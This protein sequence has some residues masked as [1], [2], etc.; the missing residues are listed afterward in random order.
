MSALTSITRRHTS[1]HS[2]A[3]ARLER[4]VRRWARRERWVRSVSWG[5]RA[6]WLSTGAGCTLAAI[7]RLRPWLL[8]ER[9][10][11][12]TAALTLGL[13]LSALVTA[14]GWPPR[15]TL[16]RARRFDRLFGLSER[17][18][19]AL[20]LLQS[21][22]LPPLLG[23]RQLEDAQRAAERVDV[24]ARLPLRV[25]KA[26]LAALLGLGALLAA[27]LLLP[28]PQADALRARQAWEQTLSAQVAA[29]EAQIE[30]IEAAEALDQAAQQA[31]T[32]P[33]QQAADTLTQEGITPQEAVAALTEAQQAL[34]ALSDGMPPSAQQAYQEAAQALAGTEAGLPLAQALQQADLGATAD[35]LDT[36]ATEAGEG[37]LSEAERQQL[38]DGLETAA[39]ALEA[40]NPAL[41]QQFRQAAQALREGDPNAA[42]QALHEAATLAAQ[43]DAALQQSELAQQAQ[44]AA[45]TL[46]AS[47]QALT[48][49][50]QSSASAQQAANAQP[51]AA[52]SGAQ[53]GEASA[54][55]S[56][57]ASSGAGGEQPSSAA[58]AESGGAGEN[59]AGGAPQAG[60][61]AGGDGQEG[62][63]LSEVSAGEG[64]NA[65]SAAEG[66][67]QSYTS[68]NPST[69]L[70][71]ESN[72]TMTLDVESESSPDNADQTVI[73]AP[74]AE[75][76]EA[77]LGYGEVLRRY[78]E[79][80][81][82]ALENGRIPLDQRDVIHDYFTSLNQQ[83]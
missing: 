29:L 21:G 41:A 50:E 62:T 68:Q 60:T 77:A 74:S 69:A 76:A 63:T 53:A 57:G 56:Q 32:E 36:L 75:G 30:A 45:Q 27:L 33:L 81:N 70:G 4:D 7:G 72:Q 5:V 73:V 19:T 39:D 66:D 2:D 80:V 25:H 79:A 34:Q 23:A 58:Q 83:P 37:A 31:L 52:T 3:Y 26:E 44:A 51:Q 43:Q 35:A 40:D 64:V 22:A 13:L 16:S 9:I 38:A 55:G 8:P 11:E 78:R 67:I 15:D 6:L 28:N 1:P 20:E 54:G 65:P 10:A 49:A 18:S 61:G 42:Q 47:T 14:W 24:R 48:Q 12:A 17:V 71:G 59:A 46:Q 82:A